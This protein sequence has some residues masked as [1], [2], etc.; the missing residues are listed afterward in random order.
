M[1]RRS[2][3]AG[4]FSGLTL[5]AMA[6]TSAVSPPAAA[7]G[8][9]PTTI[10][11]VP[12]ASPTKVPGEV[13]QATKVPLDV[14]QASPSAASPA[15][16]E[17]TVSEA[18]VEPTV[19]VAKTESKLLD[20]DERP[21]QYIQVQWETDFSRHTVRYDEIL[22]G[23]PRRDGIPPIDF[24]E[25]ATVAQ[26]PEYMNL[27][28]PVIALEI[29]GDARAYPL[30]VLIWHEIVNDEVGGIPVSITYCP[31]CNTAITF[32]RRVGDRVL[33]FGTSG[34]VRK[35]DLVMWDRQTES[36][37]Q[38]ITGEAIV[39]E[40]TLTK[41]DFIPA[42]LTS[43]EEFADA[44]PD[45]QV[46]TRNTGFYKNYASPPYQ[47][48]DYLDTEPFLFRGSIDPVLPSMERVIGLDLGQAKVAYPFSGF[49]D[50]PVVHD[51]VSGQEIVIFFA[52]GTLS[53][54]RGRGFEERRVVGTTGVF[55]PA[56]DGRS[57]TFAA[58]N[59]IILD[60]Q[61]GSEWNLL[62]QAVAGEL[63]GKNLEPL[64]HANHFWFA[65]QAFFPNTEIRS[66]DGI[67]G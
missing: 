48:Y 39:G 30:A 65:W 10:P 64:V 38:Q 34:M 63:Q 4:A 20:P 5:V 56:V 28:E 24:P 2:L 3:I 35:S 43:W 15:L 52:G 55:S 21:S 59:G 16:T 19:A 51:T 53:A 61:T 1:P 14:T 9:A 27:L 62:G 6:C 47:G 37:W 66:A 11:S 7:P 67:S 60:E 50:T 8:A 40:L 49:V 26:A 23:G 42:P 45:G 41:L 32:D 54:F 36:W 17:T 13:P 58:E 46:L 57:L 29:N 22:S 25:F 44:Y 18:E 33:D 12:T 31:L